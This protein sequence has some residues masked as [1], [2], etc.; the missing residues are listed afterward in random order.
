MQQEL[1]LGYNEYLV[2]LKY[3]ALKF[4]EHYGPEK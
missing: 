1:K 2:A 3:S 4:I